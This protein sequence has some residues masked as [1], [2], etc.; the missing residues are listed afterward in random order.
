MPLTLA[1]GEHDTNWGVKFQ[2]CPAPNDIGTGRT[3]F[4]V[5]SNHGSFEKHKNLILQVIK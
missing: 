1:A 2:P 4:V 3:K 5:F